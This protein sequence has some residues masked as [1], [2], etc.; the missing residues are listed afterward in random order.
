MEYPI[1]PPI[2]YPKIYKIFFTEDKDLL[3]WNSVASIELN[4]FEDLLFEYTNKE[5]SFEQLSSYIRE[6]YK[7]FLE[8]ISKKAEYSRLNKVLGT[9][10]IKFNPKDKE[11][12]TSY[13]II[14][15]QLILIKNA[16][17]EGDIIEIQGSRTRFKYY[18]SK[19]NHNIKITRFFHKDNDVYQG[20]VLPVEALKGIKLYDIHDRRDIEKYYPNMRFEYIRIPYKY[21]PPELSDIP[22]DSLP[23]FFVDMDWDEVIKIDIGEDNPYFIYVLLGKKYVKYFNRKV[24]EKI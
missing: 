16:S 10:S 7:E 3:E 15:S 4:K 24:S 5:L 21:Y 22:D 17:I 11:Y 1:T 6:K 19:Y 12:F 18:I 23:F 8:K 2:S 14:D 13:N 20:W 9:N